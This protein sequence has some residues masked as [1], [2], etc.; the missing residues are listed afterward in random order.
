MRH[1]PS[2]PPSSSSSSRLPPPGRV[3]GDDEDEA[4][5]PTT[6]DTTAPAEED[7]FE[8]DDDA[9]MLSSAI[10][11]NNATATIMSGGGLTPSPLS[12]GRRRRLR[13]MEPRNEDGNAQRGLKRMFARGSEKAGAGAGAGAGAAKVVAPD[14]L[15]RLH[16]RMRNP[17]TTESRDAV[18]LDA[19]TYKLD[20]LIKPDGYPWHGL[21][22]KVG[23]CFPSIHYVSELRQGSAEGEGYRLCHDQKWP[24]AIERKDS[25]MQ[26]AT[27]DDTGT[28]DGHGA[29]QW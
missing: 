15:K 4:A 25:R 7:N 21:R 10:I 2:L 9:A 1:H 6:S 22:R 19:S 14:D 27:P 24:P 11:S 29:H 8:D 17:R 3:V 23:L 28:D 16:K 18:P 20:P 5:R 26:G 13:A 12:S